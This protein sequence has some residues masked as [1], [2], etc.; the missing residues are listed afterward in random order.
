MYLRDC[1]DHCF[2]KPFSTR[3]CLMPFSI[4]MV[5]LLFYIMFNQ[6]FYSS[7]LFEKAL[8]SIHNAK[9]K[10][11]ERYQ[12]ASIYLVMYTWFLTATIFELWKIG[13]AMWNTELVW[14]RTSKIFTVFQNNFR[15]LTNN[16]HMFASQK[17]G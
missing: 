8:W 15:Y 4:R 17:I 13:Y 2:L 11:C 12:I 5:F 9:M 10:N 7:S 16:R 6:H 14:W 1:T 3:T